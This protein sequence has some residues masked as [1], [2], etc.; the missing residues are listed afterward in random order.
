M[1]QYVIP[2]EV[3]M[4]PMDVDEIREILDQNSCENL[5]KEEV[6][7]FPENVKEICI[8]LERKSANFY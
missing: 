7:V 4:I 2:L 5:N 6:I 8:L 3:L 1:L